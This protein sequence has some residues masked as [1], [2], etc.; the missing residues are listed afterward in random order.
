MKQLK[1]YVYLLTMTALL[2]IIA[3]I[4]SC[5]NNPGQQRYK[6]KMKPGKV[7]CPVKDC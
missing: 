4:E 6:G 7:D 3:P 5:K 1:S 2:L